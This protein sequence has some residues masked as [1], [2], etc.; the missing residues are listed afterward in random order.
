MSTTVIQTY[1]IA[2]GIGKSNIKPI[3]IY[4]LTYFNYYLMNLEN[5]SQVTKKLLKEYD[6]IMIDCSLADSVIANGLTE[7]PEWNVL[8]LEVVSYET[9]ITDVSALSLYLQ[10]TKL[11]WKYRAQ[12]QDR[13]CQAMKNNRC[14][15]PVLGVSSVLNTMLYIRGNRHDFDQWESFGNPEWAYDNRKTPNIIAQKKSH[16][17]KYIRNV[18]VIFA[19]KEVILSVSAINTPQLLMLSGIDVKNH[20]ENLNIPVIQDSPGVGQNLQDHIGVGGLIFL[21]DYNI[22]LKTSVLT[23]LNAILEYAINEKGS[24]ASSIGLEVV[25]NAFCLTNDFY[26]NAYNEIINHDSFSI[27]SM[28]LRPK[29]RKYVKLNSKNLLNYPLMYHDY[30][31]NPD[32]VNVLRRVKITIA[33]AETSSL[34][35]LRARLYSKSLL[36]CK[37][38]TMFIDEYWECAI[39]QFT[40][41]I[42]HIIGQVF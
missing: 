40:M 22:S 7:N 34:K 42:Y 10:N 11:N 3:L 35:K 39:C 2:L 31:M 23:N 5:Q 26:D 28:I 27:I 17:A 41:T 14:V 19:K 33:F 8:L 30:L 18:E 6:S 16:G 15:E 25:A 4:A 37:H 20:L 36:N 29:S 21:V 13:A 9:E 38:L 1:A 12:A 32:D 24:L